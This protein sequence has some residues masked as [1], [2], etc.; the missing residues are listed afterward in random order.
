MDVSIII[1]NYNTK[2]LLR[3]CLRSIY[4]NT[5]KITFE[6]FVVDN[7]SSDGSGE[8]IKKNF[9][10][11]TLIANPDNAGFG[12][13][14]NSAIKYARGKYLFFLNPDTVLLNNAIF[15]FFDFAESN[16]HHKIGAIGTLLMDNDKNVIHSYYPFPSVFFEILIRYGFLFFKIFN[17]ERKVKNTSNLFQYSSFFKGLFGLKKKQELCNSEEYHTQKGKSPLIV[18]YVTGADLFVPKSVLDS[19]G[20]FDKKYFMFSEEVDLQFRMRRLGYKRYIIDTP[21]I[22]HLEGQSTKDSNK[23][24]IMLQVSKMYFYKKNY[25]YISYIFYKV[26]YMI[27]IIVELLCDIFRKEYSLSENIVFFKHIFNN[28]YLY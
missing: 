17:I 26:A 3:N 1:V 16:K 28:R 25:G 8:M 12:S 14:N 23:K 22:V 18:D 11:V 5:R 19:T 7:A 6:I 24:R 10:G 27:S 9:P 21:K 4:D 2:E 15:L 13:A 20:F